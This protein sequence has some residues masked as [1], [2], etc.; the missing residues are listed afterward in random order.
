M[1]PSSEVRSDDRVP[2]VDDIEVEESGDDDTIRA[3]MGTW[4]P[5]VGEEYLRGFVETGA[6]AGVHQA[7]AVMRQ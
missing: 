3:F 6:D 5:R 7:S 1:R 2:S 4:R